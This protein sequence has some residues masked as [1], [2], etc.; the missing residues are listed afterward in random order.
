MA[1]AHSASL[2]LLLVL[3]HWLAGVVIL[4]EAANKLHRTD[5]LARSLS[6][7]ERGV[8]LAKVFAWIC[9]AIAAGGA[10]IRPF[11]R[12][13][14]WAPHSLLVIDRVSLVDVLALVGFAL[15]IVRSRFKE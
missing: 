1:T 14:H 5:P 8:A 10:V 11:V 4:A 2:P 15:L 9:L 7:R 12:A 3:L 6:A 13:N